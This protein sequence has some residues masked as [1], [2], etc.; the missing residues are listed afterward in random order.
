AL[1]ILNHAPSTSSGQAPGSR[2]ALRDKSRAP[3]LGRVFEGA[4]ILALPPG[5]FQDAPLRR[6]NG[7]E[8]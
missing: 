6:H 3:R 2:T 5:H 4:S 7:T 8:P 1:G